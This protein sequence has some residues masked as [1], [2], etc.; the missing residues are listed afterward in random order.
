M[1]GRYVSPDA[2][3]LEREWEILYRSPLDDRWEAGF[4]N[5]AP[6]KVLPVVRREDGKSFVQ[7][8]RWGF[9]PTWWKPSRS[10][11]VSARRWTGQR[12]RTTLAEHSRLWGNG[13]RRLQPWRMQSSHSRRHSRFSAP[14]EHGGTSAVLI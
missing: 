11:L 4:Y 8:M 13:N 3:A 5:A 9:I 14:Q 6:T 10:A 12:P 7:P 2:R 1:C